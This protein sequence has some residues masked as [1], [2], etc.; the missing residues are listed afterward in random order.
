MGMYTLNRHLRKEKAGIRKDRI[1]AAEKR[2][3][4]DKENK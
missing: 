1:K 3:T 4:E 2:N